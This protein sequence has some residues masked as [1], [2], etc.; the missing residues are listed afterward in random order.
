M[1]NNQE[2]DIEKTVGSGEPVI[3]PA[4]AYDE[5][6]GGDLAYDPRTEQVMGVNGQTFL[7]ADLMDFRDVSSRGEC[8]LPSRWKRGTSG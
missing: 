6:K 5:E 3:T 4:D 1:A 2:K 8:S 7:Q